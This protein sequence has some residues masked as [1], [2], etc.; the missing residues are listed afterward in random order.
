M[1]VKT[2]VKAGGNTCCGSLINVSDNAVAVS[3]ASG[4]ATTA[5]T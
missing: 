5:T 2:N 1:K 4:G 3:V